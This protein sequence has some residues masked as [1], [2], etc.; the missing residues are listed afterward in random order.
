LS[1]EILAK[2]LP[3]QAG[4]VLFNCYSVG[5]AYSAVQYYITSISATVRLPVV[6]VRIPLNVVGWP[7]LAAK[8]ASYPPSRTIFL[9]IVR[10]PNILQSM[11]LIIAPLAAKLYAEASVA[12]PVELIIA[13]AEELKL[14]VT[15]LTADIATVQVVAVVKLLQSPPH[16]TKV[17]VPGVSVSV[18]EVVES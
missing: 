18:T 11:S 3:E 6:T 10:G 1:R 7:V 13:C 9:L 16:P 4:R 5:K 17:D 12:Y 2:T 8:E 14:A 15:F